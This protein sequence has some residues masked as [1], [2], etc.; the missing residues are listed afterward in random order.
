MLGSQGP[1]VIVWV[2]K[3]ASH[4]DIPVIRYRVCLNYVDTA[5]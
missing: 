4:Y 2:G 3:K 5:R 1:P